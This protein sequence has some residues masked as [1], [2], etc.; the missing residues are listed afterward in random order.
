MLRQTFQNG[1]NKIQ[2]QVQDLRQSMK[3]ISEA[4]GGIND[5]VNEAAEGVSDIATKTA[6]ITAGAQE[7]SQQI[8]HSRE[9]LEILEKIV[10]KFQI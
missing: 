9:Q 5:T 6:D 10:G 2:R 3:E 1:M 7:N 8:R 4:L